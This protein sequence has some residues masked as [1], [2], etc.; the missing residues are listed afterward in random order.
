MLT[1]NWLS[2]PGTAGIG[3]VDVRLIR[4]IPELFMTAA[5]EFFG[6]RE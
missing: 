4:D 6:H 2:N 3:D 5:S 1:E